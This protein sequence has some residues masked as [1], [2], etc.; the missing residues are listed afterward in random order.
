[1]IYYIDYENVK[2][3]GLDGIEYLGEK[4]LLYI[5]YSCYAPSVPRYYDRVIKE[6]KIGVITVKLFQQGK[7]GLDFYIATQAGFNVANQNEAFA[8]I[9][10]DTGF[11][12]IKDY[13][14]VVS[15]N[16]IDV[17]LGPTVKN[18]LMDFQNELGHF[19]R[20]DQ[21]TIPVSLLGNIKNKD[22]FKEN[23][24]P[25]K[26][27]PKNNTERNLPDN[28]DEKEE[29]L[30]QVFCEVAPL[31]CYNLCISYFKG[32]AAQVYN[33]IK[34]KA[35]PLMVGEEK[36]ELVKILLEEGEDVCLRACKRKFGRTL[37][38]P[39][40]K[41]I[42]S[43]KAEI[44]CTNG[45]KS[46]AVTWETSNKK[47]EIIENNDEA[48]EEAVCDEPCYD[49]YGSAESVCIAGCILNEKETQTEEIAKILAGTKKS[50]SKYNGAFQGIKISEIEACIIRL[51]KSGAY[52]IKDGEIFNVDE[53]ILK[54]FENPDPEA[55]INNKDLSEYK[56]IDWINL[57]NS[58][59]I[60]G[61]NNW[62]NIDCLFNRT[63]LLHMMR[64]EICGFLRRAPKNTTKKIEKW[65]K[66]KK[67]PNAN[68][69]SYIVSHVGKAA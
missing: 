26:E 63:F 61:Q 33:R 29:E 5:F 16:Q 21:D 66:G 10:E 48:A 13:W 51:S 46:S 22:Y 43:I 8:I 35:V 17:Y 32:N 39:V 7:N 49:M 38:E 9:S 3:K 54:D 68:V 57:F 65:K 6:K 34:E 28:Y 59:K 44:T 15:K 58:G 50:K 41:Y 31:K 56:D 67:G 14:E 62:N 19:V 20:S 36:N 18:C 60:L 11:Q 40:W 30:I 64:E 23:I 47:T 55:F 1:M 25:E 52:S 12:S 2:S 45:E 4:D 37:G 27:N 42:C 69:L 24:E 53:E